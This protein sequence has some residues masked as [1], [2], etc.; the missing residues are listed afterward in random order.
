VGYEKRMSDSGVDL[1]VVPI[2]SIKVAP[3][4]MFNQ[5]VLVHN[6]GAISTLIHF[7]P[8]NSSIGGTCMFLP[9]DKLA[10]FFPF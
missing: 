3:D 4:I 6:G 10:G 7:L 8:A 2:I 1:S 5:R 9:I